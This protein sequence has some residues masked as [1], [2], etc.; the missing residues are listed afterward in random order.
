MGKATKEEYLF[1]KR[2]SKYAVCAAKKLAEEKKF[3]L[4]KERDNGIFRIAEQM[5]RGDQDVGEKCVL[6]DNENLRFEKIT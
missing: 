6:D 1:A 4:I 5:Y 3:G 2:A